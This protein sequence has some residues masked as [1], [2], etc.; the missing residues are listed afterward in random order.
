MTVL[1][2]ALRK[3]LV[4]LRPHHW[5]RRVPTV[6]E[7]MV[8]PTRHHLYRVEPTRWGLPGMDHESPKQPVNR[9]V[10]PR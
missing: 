6:Q 5:P 8:L 7:A 1:E 2:T 3:V 9:S 4:S 10:V